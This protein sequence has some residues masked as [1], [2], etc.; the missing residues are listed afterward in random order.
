MAPLVMFVIGHLL[1]SLQTDVDLINEQLYTQFPGYSEIQVLRVEKK[2][3]L[4]RPT[5]NLSSASG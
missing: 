1:V 3:N 5:D 4:P 2:R